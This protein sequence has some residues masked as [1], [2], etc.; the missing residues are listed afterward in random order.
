MEKFFR[1]A[2][3]Q[4]LQRE[5]DEKLKE[6]GFVDAESGAEKQYLKAY[7]SFK[8]AATYS[9]EAPKNVITRRGYKTMLVPHELLQVEATRE[10]FR[11][12]THFLVDHPFKS[13]RHRDM[14][15]MHVEGTS[16][17]AIADKYGVCIKRVRNIVDGG[18][19][20]ITGR[21]KGKRR[22]WLK[23]KI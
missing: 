7:H 8:K 19:D 5:W 15:R 6:S 20:L 16:L 1:S 3:F 22:A 23:S 4:A 11:L 17:K 2:Q 12:A 13:E 21:A 9:K 10:Y 14:W 18:R